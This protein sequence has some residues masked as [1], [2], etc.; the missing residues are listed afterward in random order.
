MCPCQETCGAQGQGLTLRGFPVP[1]FPLEL[2]SLHGTEPAVT[3][4]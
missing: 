3:W 4:G 1:A 2:I